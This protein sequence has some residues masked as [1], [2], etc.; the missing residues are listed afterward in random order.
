MFNVQIELV[1]DIEIR[2][3]GLKVYLRQPQNSFRIKEQKPFQHIISQ[4][5][6]FRNS[7]A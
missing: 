4:Y 2:N 7:K 3:E 1:S 5:I 6:D